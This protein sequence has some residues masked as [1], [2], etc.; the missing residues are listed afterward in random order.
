MK[1]EKKV[2][3]LSFNGQ[4]V[5]EE[6][7]EMEEVAVPSETFTSANDSFDFVNGEEQLPA[8]D[9]DAVDYKELYEIG[10]ADKKEGYPREI[11]ELFG[12]EYDLDNLKDEDDKAV[13]LYTFGYFP[14]L[15]GIPLYKVIYAFRKIRKLFI[16]K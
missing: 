8:V 13:R 10:R 12:R 11:S 4:V 5:G 3:E 7:Y 6:A 1:K 15:Y 9:P 16:R 14:G 2:Q